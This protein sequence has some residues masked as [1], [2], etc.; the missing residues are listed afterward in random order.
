MMPTGTPVTRRSLDELLAV[1][2]FAHR[3]RGDGA[4]RL[5]PRA[6]ARRPK[7]ASVRD[8]SAIGRSRPLRNTSP[9]SRIISF[10]RS[11]TSMRP[12]RR[13]SAITM[14]T[15]LVPTSIAASRTRPV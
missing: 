11:T 7:V 13:T 15:E 6:H 8:A 10:M 1:A 14:W 2:G 4:P 12:P 3:A 5:T 9:P